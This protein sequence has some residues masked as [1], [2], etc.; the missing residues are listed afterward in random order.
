[1]YSFLSFTS[2]NR[3]ILKT[4]QNEPNKFI[5]YNN[6]LTATATK[7]EIKERRIKYQRSMVYK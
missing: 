6:G 1:M 7:I 3:G 5:A 2:V 4:I